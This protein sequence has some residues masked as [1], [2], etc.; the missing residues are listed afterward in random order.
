MTDIAMHA[1]KGGMPMKEAAEAAGVHRTTLWRALQKAKTAT[2]QLER[3]RGGRKRE[4]LEMLL[5]KQMELIYNA[6]ERLPPE[7]L[8][9]QGASFLKDLA[10]T[11]TVN[12]GIL[13][14]KIAKSEE[15]GEGGTTIIINVPDSPAR[16]GEQVEQPAEDQTTQAAPT[17]EVKI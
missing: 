4:A 9:K 2:E 14:D 12:M 6:L 11:G 13:I 7:E 5:S 15:A 10:R 1:V 3:V 17:V 8:D 16:D